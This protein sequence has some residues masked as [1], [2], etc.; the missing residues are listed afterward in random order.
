VPEANIRDQP[1]LPF[2]NPNITHRRSPTSKHSPP[3]RDIP[4]V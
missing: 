1:Q 2:L 4:N 3:Y